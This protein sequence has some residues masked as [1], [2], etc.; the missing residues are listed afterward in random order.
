MLM[1]LS[2][3]LDGLQHPLHALD[4]R[5]RLVVL[6]EPCLDAA[7][8]HRFSVG[9]VRASVVSGTTGSTGLRAGC[10]TVCQ[11]GLELFAYFGKDTATQF[12][13]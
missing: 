13:C 6:L 8:Q 10:D 5:S 2:A 11:P 7:P 4:L 1:L 3:S 12:W 9:F